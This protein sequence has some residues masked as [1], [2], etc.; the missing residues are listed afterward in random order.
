MRIAKE[1]GVAHEVVKGDFL[2]AVIPGVQV[3]PSG[4]LAINGAQRK[5]CTYCFAG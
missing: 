2:A 1:A 4:V 3:V 5:G